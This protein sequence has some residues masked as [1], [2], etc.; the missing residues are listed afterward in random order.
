MNYIPTPC[1]KVIFLHLEDYLL[2]C[3]INIFQLRFGGIIPAVAND[4]HR[5]CITELC[6]DA[7]RSGNLKLRDITAIATTV[8]PGLPLSLYI[9]RDFGVRLSEI[10]KKPFIPIHHMEAHALVA[11]MTQQVGIISDIHLIGYK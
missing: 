7:L 8:K 4:L 5:K 10:G 2:Q 3:F 11:R 9:G 1:I 6:E